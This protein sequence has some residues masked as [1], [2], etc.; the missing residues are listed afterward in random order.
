MD[1]N[2]AI[3]YLE[4]KTISFSNKLT[5]WEKWVDSMDEFKQ[6]NSDIYAMAPHTR[7]LILEL[8]L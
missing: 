1:L 7:P 6:L 4:D 8:P 2:Q 3:Q 5:V